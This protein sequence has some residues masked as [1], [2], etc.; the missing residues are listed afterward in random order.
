MTTTSAHTTTSHT[1]TKRW[2]RRRDT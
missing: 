1:N 2:Q